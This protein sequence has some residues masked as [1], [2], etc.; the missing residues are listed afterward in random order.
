MISYRKLVKNLVFDGRGVEW[1]YLGI[2]HYEILS[3]AL[4]SS[5][6]DTQNTSIIKVLQICS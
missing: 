2:L 1:G 3:Q 6:T 5:E 4:I